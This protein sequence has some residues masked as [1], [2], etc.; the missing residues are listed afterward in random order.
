MS[1]KLCMGRN[2]N[3]SDEAIVGVGR[4]DLLIDMIDVYMYF[5]ACI[6]LWWLLNR[7]FLFCFSRILKIKSFGTDETY[8]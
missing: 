6:A 3:G 5:V 4:T 2:W 7:N 1:V 8:V